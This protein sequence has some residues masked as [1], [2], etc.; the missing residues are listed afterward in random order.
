MTAVP[1]SSHFY[2]YRDEKPPESIIQ[3]PGPRL[4]SLLARENIIIFV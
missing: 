3:E 1:R 2:E 4:R